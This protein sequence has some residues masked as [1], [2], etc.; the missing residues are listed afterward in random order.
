MADFFVF[1]DFFTILSNKEACLRAGI[2][3]GSVRE[4][5]DTARENPESDDVQVP[6]IVLI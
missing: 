3:P 5:P 6:I 2:W 4:L 1:L